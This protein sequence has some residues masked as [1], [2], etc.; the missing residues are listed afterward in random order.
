MRAFSLRL[1]AAVVSAGAL[2]VGCQ[3]GAA[4]NEDRD[5]H[6]GS[7]RAAADPWAHLPPVSTP[8]PSVPVT[9]AVPA[10]TPAPPRPAAALD[11]GADAAVGLKPPPPGLVKATR[12][13]L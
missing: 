4:S 9:V 6:M 1:A 11:A 7:I 13:P 2:L 5:T 8:V 12:L 3:D 10:L